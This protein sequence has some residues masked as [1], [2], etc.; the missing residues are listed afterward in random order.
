MGA[1][2][3]EQI[4]PDVFCERS[5]GTWAVYEHSRHFGARTVFDGSPS[6]GHGPDGPSGLARIPTGLLDLVLEAAEECPGECIHVEH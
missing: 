4:V 3:C 1:G 6:A 2:T 5:D